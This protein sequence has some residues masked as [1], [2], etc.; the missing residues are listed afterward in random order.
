[1]EEEIKELKHRIEVLSGVV[2]ILL[3]ETG[4]LDKAIQ[5]NSLLKT[6]IE[7]TVGREEGKEVKDKSTSKQKEDEFTSILKDFDAKDAIKN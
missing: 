5:N 6:V 2:F 7:R 3:K 4:L 1:M